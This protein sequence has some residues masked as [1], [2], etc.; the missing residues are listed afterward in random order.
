MSYCLL[1]R[2]WLPETRLEISQEL[3]YGRRFA[4]DWR[5]VDDFTLFWKT[6]NGV[7]RLKNSWQSKR[8]LLCSKWNILWTNFYKIFSF[9]R[10]GSKFLNFFLPRTWFLV[11]EKS[12]IIFR[13]IILFLNFHYIINFRYC[14]SLQT[15]QQAI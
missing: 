7:T 1:L 14:V 4:N 2:S 15:F 8:S 10:F 3:L 6:K 13:T 5:F 9:F 12:E 11:R